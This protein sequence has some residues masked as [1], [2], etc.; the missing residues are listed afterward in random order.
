MKKVFILTGEP[1]GDKLASSVISKLKMLNSD[2]QYLCVGGKHLNS[3]GIES[4]YELKEITYL[5]FTDVLL[6]I[7]KIKKKIN[8]TVKKILEFQPDILFSVDSPDFTLRV[9]KKVKKINPNIKTIHFIA[10]KVWAWREGRVKKMKN[11]LDHILLL[12]KFEKKYF[13]KE[14]LLNTFV[15][16]PL[17][18][19]EIN[20]NVKLDNVINDK[21][22][23]ISL[24]AGSRESEIKIHAPIL[25][26]FINKFNS[27][28]SNF[29]FIFHS[30]DKY[31]GYLN[32]LLSKQNIHNAE[33]ISDDRIKNEILKKSSFAIVKSGTVSLEVCKL[34]I[35]SII[36][37]KMNYINYFLAKFFLKIR[38]ANMLNIINDK[39]I[40]PELIQK[41]CNSKEIFKS[42]YYFL[43]KPKLIEKQLFEV[44][45]AISDLKS[46]SSS[47]EEASKILLNNLT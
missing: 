10:P 23:Y 11:Y 14:K 33:V 7:F 25:F 45:E 15:G 39:E 42:V 43:K 44:K 8:Q 28:E 18:D 34:N 13:D 22:I 12:F 26:E 31:K 20:D 35:P 40:I 30:I 4:I 27:K 46:T 17:L 36:I 24:F 32:N 47:S 21:K 2:I 19:E 9:A 37:Y 38:F 3:L 6:N 29:N 41:D 1:S 5:A 16:H